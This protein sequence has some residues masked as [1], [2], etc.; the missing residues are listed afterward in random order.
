MITHI[1]NSQRIISMKYASFIKHAILIAVTA[2][3][4]GTASG[5]KAEPHTEA[6]TPVRA[7][8]ALAKLKEGNARY[9]EGQISQDKDSVNERAEKRTETC[10]KQFPLAVI[11][12]CA[13]SRTSPEIVFDQN[14]GDLFV[15]RTAGNLAGEHAMGSI[16]YAVEHLGARLVVVLGHERCGAVKA[17][18][19]PKPD[20]NK[21][22]EAAS[23]A[24]YVG[25][26]VR[27]IQPAVTATANKLGDR[28]DLTVA[29]NARQVAARISKEAGFGELAAQVSVVSA[30]YD[31][32]TGK[33]DWDELT[34]LALN[35]TATQSSL[36]ANNPIFDASKAVDG[37]TGGMF[38][39]QP[40]SSEVTHTEDGE[41]N[42]WQVDL[43]DSYQISKIVIWNRQDMV[44][45]RL[46]NFYIMVSET[47][48]EAN[49]TAASVF[50]GPHDMTSK[51]EA[52]RHLDITGN[53]KGRYV[54][55]FLQNSRNP[56]SL[57][58]VQVFG[59][60]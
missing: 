23:P 26:L 22:H 17:A 31:L 14:I 35:K 37:N 43:G 24:K 29:E 44:Q 47:P 48:I 56:L 51:E 36:I 57:A 40:L 12:G 54:R 10:L 6:K 46:A 7:E 15:V 20:D 38:V 19:P 42:W 21:A 2:T 11:V 34:N 55:V 59:R 33:V 60:K 53:A 58:E 18:L 28:W 41:G 25:S 3:T 39:Q 49:S 9:V 52:R 1:T 16:E 13:D 30:V 8:E 45:E 50:S 5:E 4:A 32:D 27:D